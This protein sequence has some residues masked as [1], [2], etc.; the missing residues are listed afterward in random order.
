V[1][2]TRR[3]VDFLFQDP[4]IDLERVFLIGASYGGITGCSVVAFEPRIKRATLVMAGGNL[5]R[6]LDALARSRLPESP[7]LASAG[8]S[9]VAWLLR[10]FEPLDFIWKVAPRPVLFL[11]VDSDEMIDSACAQALY[12]AAGEP[13]EQMIYRDA[14]NAISEQTV[15][16]MLGDALEWMQATPVIDRHT[17]RVVDQQ[18]EPVF[19][20]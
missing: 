20:Q 2:E 8:A 19:E 7:F 17:G 14:H 9:L 18:I 10:P 6:L 16:Q 11:N 3:L 4:G 12:Q 13:R 5:P 1:P 15:R